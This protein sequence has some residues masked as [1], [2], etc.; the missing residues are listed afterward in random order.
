MHGAHES[1]AP[2]LGEELRAGRGLYVH[3]GLYL[4]DGLAM[5]FGGGISDK[6]RAS[7]PLRHG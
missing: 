4:G 6:L 1:E 5:Q 3:H 2:Q 7:R